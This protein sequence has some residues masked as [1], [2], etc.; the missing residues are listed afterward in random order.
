MLLGPCPKHVKPRQVVT[1]T[2]LLLERIVTPASMKSA[3][4]L[5]SLLVKLYLWGILY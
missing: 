5:V 2:I 1:K 3:V 4:I